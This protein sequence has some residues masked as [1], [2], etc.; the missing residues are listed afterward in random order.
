MDNILLH[1]KIVERN[2]ESLFNAFPLMHIPTSFY[3]NKPSKPSNMV[4]VHLKSFILKLK[5][6]FVN[7]HY[8]LILTNLHL[9]PQHSITPMP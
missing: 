9:T 8:F 1:S 6:L 7:T 3:F 4:N 2:S 5:P